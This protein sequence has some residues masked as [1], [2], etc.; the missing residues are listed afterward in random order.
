M[1]E[2]GCVNRATEREQAFQQYYLKYYAKLAK[3][4]KVPCIVWDNGAE[5]AGEERHAF[6]DHGTGDYCS[7]EAK[8]AMQAL[9]SSYN[10]NL[11][12]DDVYNNAPMN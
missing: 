12:L 2:F 6:F 11:T 1:G 8:A 9:V 10:D 5:G 3:T 7:P 4:Y